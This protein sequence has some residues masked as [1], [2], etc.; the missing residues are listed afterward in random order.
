MIRAQVAGPNEPIRH[1]EIPEL[2]LPRVRSITP[3]EFLARLTMAEKLTIRTAAQSNAALAVWID[4]L[5][6]STVVDLDNADT[7]N[8]LKA[9]QAAGLITAAR[10]AEILA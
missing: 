10:M 8:G 7:I 3:R 5:V 4:E 9:M 1:E 6:A 2:A